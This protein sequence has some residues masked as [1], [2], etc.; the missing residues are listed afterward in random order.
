[1]TID[2]D[3]ERHVYRQ[4]ADI[5]RAQI[6]SGELPGGARL[7]SEARL[8]REYRV[9][10]HTARHAVGLLVAEGLVRTVVG[11][12]QFVVPETERP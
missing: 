3:G 12:G 8:R 6:T 4:L 2:P 7:P 10:R 9:S 5:L 1:M 11:R